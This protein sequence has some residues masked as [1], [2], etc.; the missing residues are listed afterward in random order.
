[1]SPVLTD[2]LPHARLTLPAEGSYL[3]VLRTATAGLAA[4]INFTIDDIEDLRLA[5]DEACAL[6]L[7]QALPSSGRECQFWL[8]QGRMTV[9]VSAEC[10]SP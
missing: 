3:S 10:D 5:V 6:L 2:T 1:M 8:G 7:A 4:R 9:A